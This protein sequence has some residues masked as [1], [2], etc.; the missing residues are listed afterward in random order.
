MKDNICK[1]CGGTLGF[2]YHGFI[3]GCEC[4]QHH[5][6]LHEVEELQEIKHSSEVNNDI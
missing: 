2:N 1:H 4:E 5:Q 6:A 3:I